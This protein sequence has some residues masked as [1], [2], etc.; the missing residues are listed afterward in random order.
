[1]IDGHAH[2]NE[3][4][5]IEQVLERAR[6][7]GIRGIVA[8]GMDLESNRQTL[9]LAGRYPG[10]VFP[11][12]G[13]H[14]WSISPD[15]IEENLLFLEDHLTSCVA[16]GEVGLDYRARVKKKVQQNVF[17]RILELASKRDKPVIV[18][19]RYSHS[20]AHNMVREA[21]IKKAVFHW[22]SGP[23]DILDRIIADG[24]VISATPALS[25]SP[26]HQAAIKRA[27]MAHILVETDA[28]VEY[29]GKVSEPSDLTATLEQLSGIKRITLPDAVR[30]TAENIRKTFDLNLS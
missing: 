18:H 20:R 17:A 10:F 1:M 29:Q 22:Y 8:V 27:P 9:M 30:A 7:V 24:Y 25:Y 4:Q 12:I 2:L 13:Y 19:A 5:G 11:A 6:Q 28:P 14:P 21:G 3:I 15:G 26:P 23:L 16:L